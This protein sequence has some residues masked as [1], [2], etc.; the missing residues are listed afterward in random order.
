MLI[1][2]TF[3]NAKQKSHPECEDLK[4]ISSHVL[5]DGLSIRILL[6]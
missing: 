1:R 4:G 5:V 3:L 6:D 2:G